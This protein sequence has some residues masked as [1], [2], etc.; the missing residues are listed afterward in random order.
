MFLKN[1][2]NNKK[3]YF[4]K[5]LFLMNFINYIKKYFQKR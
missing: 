5:M 2:N 1:K 4:R 3:I